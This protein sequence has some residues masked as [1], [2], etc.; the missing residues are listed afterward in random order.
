VRT[1]HTADLAPAEL[2]DARALLD[3]AFEGDFDDG[4]WEHSLGGLHVLVSDEQGLAAHGSVIQRRVRYRKRWLR[5]GY[6]EGVGV[7]ADVRRRG[8]GGRVM[9]EV[10]RIIGGAYDIGALSAS[11][12][13]A[14]L[15][16][17]RGWQLWRG[18]VCA[19]GPR[20]VVRLRDEEDCTYVRTAGAGP[21]DLK[22]KLVFDWRDGD[23]L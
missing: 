17:A 20:G 16:A 14:H 10:E 1:V 12:D 18:R 11:D 5:V 8:L 4:D 6:V 19:L 9:A 3:A 13:G 15:Y 23:V 22:R 7:R 2:R 21:L